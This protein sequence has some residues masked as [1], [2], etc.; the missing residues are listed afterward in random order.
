MTT[1]RTAPD[2]KQE[3]LKRSDEEV[4]QA[5]DAGREMRKPG[6]LNTLK[7]L[8]GLLWATVFAFFS[9]GCSTM[10]GALSFNTFL[11]LPALLTLILSLVGRLPIHGR[12]RASSSV[13]SAT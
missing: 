8:L 9:D 11:S 4:D 3:V 13:R 6:L 10:A 5:R 2:G 1:S 7:G 12:S